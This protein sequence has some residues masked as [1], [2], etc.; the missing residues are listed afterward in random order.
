MTQAGVATQQD[1]DLSNVSGFGEDENH[2]LYALSRGGSA[3]A[4]ILYQVGANFPLP[5]GLLSFTGRGMNGYNE[6]RWSTSYEQNA[7]K[8][9]IEYSTDGINYTV[10]GEVT[11]ANNSSGS[12]YSFRHSVAGTGKIFY[13]LQM[14]DLDA[15]SRYSTVIAIGGKTG[16]EVK[17]YP[18]VVQNNMIELNSN[19]ALESLSVYDPA[20]K[21]IYSSNLGG[22]QGYFSIQLPGLTKGIYFVAI[23]GNNYNKTEKIVIQ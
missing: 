7:D 5:V 17:L 8:Y 20:G 14:R 12:S 23:K 9:I 18:T 6:L 19:T 11:A 22:R 1:I 4:G 15:S 10:A 3:G 2:E 13:R 21:Q 16:V